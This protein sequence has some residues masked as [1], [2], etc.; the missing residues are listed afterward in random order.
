MK[1]PELDYK[2]PEIEAAQSAFHTLQV[3][4]LEHEAIPNEKGDVHFH[5]GGLDIVLYGE[6]NK[7]P[8]GEQDPWIASVSGALEPNGE[9]VTIRVLPDGIRGLRH[10]YEDDGTSILMETDEVIDYIQRVGSYQL[11]TV[12]KAESS[13]RNLRKPRNFRGTLRKILPPT[14][15]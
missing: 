15:N 3:A 8:H 6:G 13:E 9:D 7:G 2:D 10:G 12:D 14:A 11:P 4:A 5:R 1:H